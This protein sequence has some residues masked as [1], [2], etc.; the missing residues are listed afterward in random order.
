[1]QGLAIAEARSNEY[2]FA[3]LGGVQGQHDMYTAQ[4]EKEQK[5]I[6]NRLDA[7]MLD[8]DISVTSKTYTLSKMLMC[9]FVGADAKK[10]IATTLLLVMHKSKAL[11]LMTLCNL[12]TIA[13]VCKQCA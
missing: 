1:V 9:V 6:I 7:Y 5:R 3:I 10:L 13:V 4:S 12:L 11:K 8:R 2:L